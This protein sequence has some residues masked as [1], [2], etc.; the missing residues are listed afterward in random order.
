MI[1]KFLRIEY[2]TASELLNLVFAAQ[3]QRLKENSHDIYA[4]LLFKYIKRHEQYQPAA[5]SASEVI[6]NSA[7][8][9]EVRQDG[10]TL[11]NG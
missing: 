1:L 3:Q 7:N 9:I 10:H 5:A 6:R 2:L 8:G 4:D 11:S